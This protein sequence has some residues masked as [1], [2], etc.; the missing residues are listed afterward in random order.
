M[1]AAKSKGREES[2]IAFDLVLTN[3]GGPGPED[4]CQLWSTIN[5]KK[6]L[7][8]R[9]GDYPCRSI[10]EGPVTRLLSNYYK[11]NSK[12]ISPSYQTHHGAYLAFFHFQSTQNELMLFFQILFSTRHVYG[13]IPAWDYRCRCLTTASGTQILRGRG[14]WDKSS[15]YFQSLVPAGSHKDSEGR[16][17]NPGSE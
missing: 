4:D 3:I 6:L 17:A 14:Y 1:I 10:A 2:V 16:A 9:Q 8:Y 7:F 12:L 11:N 13:Q 5:M 15:W